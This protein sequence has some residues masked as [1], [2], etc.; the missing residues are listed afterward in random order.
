MT[1]ASVRAHNHEKVIANMVIGSNGAT[2]LDQDSAPLSPPADRE[3][4][5]AIRGLASS[6]VVGGNTYRCEHYAKAPLPVFVGTR[7][8]ELLSSPHSAIE[9]E[10]FFINA[11]PNVVLHQALERK[12]AVALVEGGISFIKPLLAEQMID[13]LFLTRSPLAGDSDFFDFELLERHYQ[14][15]KSEQVEDVTFEEWVPIRN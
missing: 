14:L 5:H 2:S 15:E 10:S 6:L 8:P 13:R 3:R 4:F 11:N 9:G 1:T 12:G 7:N